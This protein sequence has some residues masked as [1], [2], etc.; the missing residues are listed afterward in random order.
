MKRN[1]LLDILKG[2]GI[3]LVVLGHCI[4]YG[5]GINYMNNGYFFE[6]TLFKFIYSFHM[7]LFVLISGYLFYNTIKKHDS[8]DIFKS[9]INRCVFP[10]FIWSIIGGLILFF[11]QKG[12]MDLLKF[13]S[14]G[15][16]NLYFLWTI[17]YCSIIVL[18]IYK[19]YNNKII[20]YLI[21][22]FFS[23]LINYRS[24]D[25]M[26]YLLPYFIIGFKFNEHKE[27]FKNFNNYRYLIIIFIILVIL[28]IF[29]FKYFST[30]KY[31]YV[32]PYYI[33][34]SKNIIIINLYRFIIGL[35]GSLIVI[36]FVKQFRIIFEKLK[37]FE[38]LGKNSMAIYIISCYLNTIF[39]MD[40][41]TKNF[42]FNYINVMVETIIILILSSI[43]T[44]L[45]RKNKY[46]KKL[47]GE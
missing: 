42:N 45:I 9:K 43:I 38:I 25:F 26:L 29:L 4:Q 32:N 22:L 23:L 15:F 39:L 28:Y 3:I 11:Q 5:N 10:V 44:Y 34:Y 35:I 19:F 18:L 17:F 6:N 13:I 40:N 33:L 47:I 41:F 21:I 31:I 46:T 20:Y 27:K 36:I 1:A 7:P 2:I 30:N 37:I 8:K 24:I 14:D 16:N 12:E